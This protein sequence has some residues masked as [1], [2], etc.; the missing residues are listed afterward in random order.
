MMDLFDQMNK[1]SSV[2][3]AWQGY[4]TSSFF[5][6]LTSTAVFFVTLI[7][8][9]VAMA[10]TI[11]DIFGKSKHAVKISA[12]IVSIFSVIF[13]MNSIVVAESVKGLYKG[14]NA[15]IG[16][17]PI[18]MLIFSVLMMMFATL[19]T[20]RASASLSAQ[21]MT[22]RYQSYNPSQPYSPNQGYIPNQAYNPNQAYTPNQSYDPNQVYNPNQAYNPNQPYNPNLFYQTGS[23]QP[24]T[25]SS[26]QQQE[27][28][29]FR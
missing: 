3:D 26:E 17:G 12:F 13:L 14:L 9:L 11:S 24:F 6:V 7:C 4:I 20:S 29:G 8:M 10:G 2:P 15:S 21:L 16:P 19:A 27:P 25:G 18:L 22:N 5:L 23:Q 28:N 1:T